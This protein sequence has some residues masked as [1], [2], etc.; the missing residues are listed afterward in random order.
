MYTG[1]GILCR[2]LTLFGGGLACAAGHHLGCGAGRRRVVDR[3]PAPVRGSPW[4]CAVCLSPGACQSEPRG[5]APFSLTCPLS[6]GPTYQAL[7]ARVPCRAPLPRP[8][9]PVLSA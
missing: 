2:P 7:S 1:G 5:C 4:T 3:S 8:A 9:A 6:A